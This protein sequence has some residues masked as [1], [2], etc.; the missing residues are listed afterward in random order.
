MRIA[1]ILI[2]P[3]LRC[4]LR[5]FTNVQV[6]EW[7]RRSL[8]GADPYASTLRPRS[9]RSHV[10]HRHCADSGSQFRFLFYVGGNCSEVCSPVHRVWTGSSHGITAAP[11]SPRQL[12][13]HPVP[14]TGRRC[15]RGGGKDMGVQFVGVEPV[16]STHVVTRANSKY[17]VCARSIKHVKL[18]AFAADGAGLSN[19]SQ[20]PTLVLATPPLFIVDGDDR[21][22]LDPSSRRCARCL[23][24]QLND[25]IHVSSFNN[26]ETCKRSVSISEGFPDH[27]RLAAPGTHS[28]QMSPP[29]PL[30]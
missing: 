13:V 10:L 3:S 5:P 21:P 4:E 29:P 24:D 11:L 1:S 26:G 17:V 7:N 22:Y 9:L 25:L 15:A 16:L 18:L 20:H 27:I 28:C 30:A 23:C 6:N 2:V 14:G 12:A 8:R 19:R